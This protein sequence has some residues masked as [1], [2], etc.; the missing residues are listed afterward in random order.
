MTSTNEL[1]RDGRRLAVTVRG[2]GPPL[3]FAHGLSGTHEDATWLHAPAEAFRLLTPDLFGRGASFPAARVGDHSF[4]EHAADVMAILDHHDADQAIV[5][6][7]SFGAAVATAFA[8]AYPERVRALVLLASAFG[9]ERDPMGEGDLERY[10]ALAD[11]M[12]IEGVRSVAESEAVRTGSKRPIERWTQHDDQS[13]IA[14]MR[15]VPVYRPFD[16]ASDLAK[17]TVPTLVVSGNDEIHT[18]ELSRS[19]AE[20]IPDA[21]FIRPGASLVRTVDVF[22]ARFRATPEG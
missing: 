1:V 14:F 10:G 4:E 16:R 2:T 5:A 8:I 19:Y 6:G 9:G 3:V 12:A 18:P 13:L 21:T 17:I 15:A 20:S 7:V 11:R 22:L